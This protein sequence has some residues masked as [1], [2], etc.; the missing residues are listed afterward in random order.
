MKVTLG[1]V[2]AVTQVDKS[3]NDA[4]EWIRHDETNSEIFYMS[5]APLNRESLVETVSELG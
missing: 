5:L 3:G 2:N 1:L 4:H